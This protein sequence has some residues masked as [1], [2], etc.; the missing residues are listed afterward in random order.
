MC[1]VSTVVYAKTDL[2]RAGAEGQGLVPA[3]FAL[4][5]SIV[6]HVV[7]PIGVDGYVQLHIYGISKWLHTTATAHVRARA[8]T[9]T[10][11]ALVVYYAPVYI[12]YMR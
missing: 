11:C 8:R 3:Y 12:A 6:V 5:I 4:M 9:C 7:K 10:P 1:W 2:C